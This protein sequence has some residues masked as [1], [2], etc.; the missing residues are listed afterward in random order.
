MEEKHGKATF[1]QNASSTSKEEHER[2]LKQNWYKSSDKW[3]EPESTNVTYGKD[4]H[5]SYAGN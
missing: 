1:F 3:D 4:H 5:V 2:N